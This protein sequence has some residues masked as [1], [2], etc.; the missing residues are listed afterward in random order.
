VGEIIYFTGDNT[1]WIATSN[2]YGSWAPYSA[3]SQLTPYNLRSSLPATALQNSIKS[4]TLYSFK[5]TIKVKA[6]VLYTDPEV[7]GTVKFTLLNYSLDSTKIKMVS[8]SC[9]IQIVDSDLQI[10]FKLTTPNWA[11]D[12]LLGAEFLIEYKNTNNTRFIP[13]TILAITDLE[14]IEVDSALIDSVPVTATDYE[15]MGYT[16]TQNLVKDWRTASVI[17]GQVFAGAGY[18]EKLYDTLIF[19][20][21]INGA[22]DNMYDAI[23]NTQFLDSDKDNFR[24]EPIVAMIILLNTQLMIFTAGGGV[25]M[26]P[27]TNQTQEVARGYGIFT[28]EAIQRFRETVYWASI[29]DIVK[30]S[31]STG[32]LAEPISEDSVRGLYNKVPDKSRSVSCIDKFGVFHLALD[33]NSATKELLYTNRGWIDQARD[34]HPIVMRNGINDIVYFMDVDGNIYKILGA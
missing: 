13:D 34:S 8:S 16:P 12:E 14:I 2:G 10:N 30:I 7:L 32:Y 11:L 18:V 9:P 29:D 1:W 23:P 19:F 27:T 22:G 25:I 5:V 20:S 6:P 28:K 33:P 21:A 15:T 31:A 24:G 4:N 3:S 26:D 17:N